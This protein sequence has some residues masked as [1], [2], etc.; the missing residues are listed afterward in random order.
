MLANRKKLHPAFQR[1]LP[2][3]HTDTIA[4]VCKYIEQ[5]ESIPTLE[6]LAKFSGL[7]NY[8][9]H[10]TFKAITGL[11]PRAYANAHRTNRIKKNLE[12]KGSITKAIIDAGFNSSS[13]FYEKSNQILGMTP[14][15]FRQGGINL[16]IHFAI[17]E[18]S[19]GSILVAS[20][21]R[22]ICAIFL[23]DDPEKLIHDL[24]DRFPKASL[25]GGDTDYE[26]TVATVIGFIETPAI[27]LDLP[28]DIQGTV[29][30]QRVWQALR[31][32]PAGITMSYSEI[33][34]QIGAPKS[35]RAVAQACAANKI[36]VAIPCHRVVRNDGNL[37]GYRW[38][39]ERKRELLKRETK[40]N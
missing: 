39:V 19:L 25:I 31:D 21:M 15:D 33:A 28:L 7:S 38:G 26:K 9:F 17:G 12:G 37:S 3:R 4:R 32:I 2:G 18:C 10:R 22:G 24:Q 16:K 14:S 27:G 5:S 34:K 35:F 30:Q 40:D 1:P 29:F 8:Y 11:T 23:G 20:S 13:R 6:E 36:A